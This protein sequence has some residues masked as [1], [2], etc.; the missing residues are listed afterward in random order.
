MSIFDEE[1]EKREFYDEDDDDETIAL[2]TRV[3]DM[4][5]VEKPTRSIPLDT[6]NIRL[7]HRFALQLASALNKKVDDIVDVAQLTG[8][9]D[10]LQRESIPSLLAAFPVHGYFIFYTWRLVNVSSLFAL[11]RN[12]QT[13][14]PFIQLIALIHQTAVH[15]K[16]V[17]YAGTSNTLRVREENKQALIKQL[18]GITSL[19]MDLT[20]GG[21]TE[22]TFKGSSTVSTIPI[23]DQLLYQAC[24]VTAAEGKDRT[25]A[26]R[27]QVNARLTTMGVKVFSVP[28]LTSTAYWC[29]LVSLAY[30]EQLDVINGITTRKKYQIDF[31]KVRTNALYSYFTDVSPW[32]VKRKYI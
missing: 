22:W 12:T 11:I 2:P 7:I 23:V 4:P 13:L 17:R 28:H 8:D 1:E 25:D 15:D 21:P 6:I 31:A 10:V 9:I 16:N 26:I 18:Y 32:A 14:S 5:A 29:E 3:I 20:E 24:L 30:F 19:A 27:Q